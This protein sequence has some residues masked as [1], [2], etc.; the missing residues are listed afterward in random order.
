MKQ[1]I[2]AGLFAVLVLV[3]AFSWVGCGTDYWGCACTMTCDGAVRSAALDVCTGQED[4]EAAMA[5]AIFTC[6]EKLSQECTT[7]LCGCN[8]WEGYA[9]CY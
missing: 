3:S 5:N 2:A 8:C 1:G 9:N 6:D 4:L 7:H